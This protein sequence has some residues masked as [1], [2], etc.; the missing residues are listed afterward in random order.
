[1]VLFIKSPCFLEIHFERIMKLSSIWDLQGQCREHS[2][3]TGS[4]DQLHRDGH[5]CPEQGFPSLGLAKVLPTSLRAGRGATSSVV[6]PKGDKEDVPCA[7]GCD[8][9]L[10]PKGQNDKVLYIKP[11]KGPK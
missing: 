2:G 9:D 6:C 4:Q 1:M 7:P 11:L 10:P 8:R 3:C 5:V